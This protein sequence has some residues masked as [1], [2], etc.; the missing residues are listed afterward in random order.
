MAIIR[1]HPHNEVSTIG[2]SYIRMDS[3]II[4]LDRFDVILGQPWYNKL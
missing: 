1:Q 3:I 2:I 4:E